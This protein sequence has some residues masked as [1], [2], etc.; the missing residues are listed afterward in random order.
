MEKRIIEIYSEL[1]EGPKKKKYL[2]EHKNID[3]TQRTVE[4]TISKY[5]EDI[6]LDKE[7][8]EYRFKNLLPKYIPHSIFF[9]LFQESIGNEIIKNDFL[10]L[11]KMISLKDDLNLPMIPTQ[12][13]SVLAQKIIMAEVAIS[14]NCIIKIDYLGNSKPLETKYIKPHKIIAT[15]FT[16]YLYVSYDDRNEE[17]IGAYR[18]LAFNG[19]YNISP[20]EYV[21]N[22]TFLIEGIGNA[23][24]LINKEKYI[25]LKLEAVSANFFK[26]EGQFNKENFDFISEEIDGSVIM[27]M[28]YNKIQEVVKLIQSWMPLITIHDNPAIT[29]EVYKIILE[30]TKRL[31]KGYETNM[32]K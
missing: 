8:G 19:M 5:S 1:Y 7:L 12:G 32:N 18:S 13:L 24:G 11:S 6:I 25:A 20:V 10:L 3:V 15:G 29:D 2:A 21:K 17:N 9:T 14:S 27:K 28:Y 16:Y 31:T 22:E 26:R 23:Y 30:N 4:N